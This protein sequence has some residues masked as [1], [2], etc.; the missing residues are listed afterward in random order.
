[1]E[2]EIPSWEKEKQ[3]QITKFFGS[4]LVFFRVYVGKILRL[5]A[6]H[7]SLNISFPTP[8]PS[9][10]SPR[11]IAPWGWSREQSC[12]ASSSNL[13]FFLRPLLAGVSDDEVC[14]LWKFYIETQH[15]AICERRYLFH[16]PSFLVSI[17]QFSEVYMHLHLKKSG[18]HHIKHR[19]FIVVTI[20]WGY[21]IN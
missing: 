20:F 7:L 12:W 2:P 19:H 16:F 14:T 21:G 8:T 13:R 15:D 4:M 11:L 5:L 3:L 10:S 9:N 18:F 6:P 17:R 1:M